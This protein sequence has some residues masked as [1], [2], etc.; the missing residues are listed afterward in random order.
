MDPLLLSENEQ[1]YVFYHSARETTTS[2]TNFV[3]YQQPTTTTT[4][5]TTTA[6]SGVFH[7]QIQ[8][9]RPSAGAGNT[10]HPL[11][12]LS[13]G[14]IASV[15]SCMS[16]YPFDTIKVLLQLDRSNAPA[17][18]SA[19]GVIRHI[20]GSERPVRNLYRGLTPSLMAIIPSQAIQFT[21][22]EK[23]KSFYANQFNCN[24][25][26]PKALIAASAT[27]YLTTCLVTNPLWLVKIRLQ[28]QTYGSALR[29][30]NAFHAFRVIRQEEG[31]LAFYKGI[32]TTVLGVAG[33]CITFPILEYMKRMFAK[34]QNVPVEKLDASYIALSA[35][36][37]SLVSAVTLFP[38]DVVRAR[39][40]TQR[41]FVPPPPA[42]AATTGPA[43]GAAA[44]TTGSHP[45]YHQQHYYTGCID[46]IRK[47]I[48]YEGFS[49]LY[50]GLLPHLMR[51]V[52]ASALTWTMYEVS[53][54]FLAKCVYGSSTEATFTP[55]TTTTSK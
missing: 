20:I 22:Y 1:Y 52:P 15:T 29:Y 31:L 35:M 40:Q 37:A 13:S 18:R 24:T 33:P 39:I 42:P 55:T 28:A 23:L 4:T 51:A 5:S 38:L 10:M 49:S 11:L 17:R 26:D 32:S 3:N 12:L 45:H 16:T 44:A 46:G 34:Q 19:F 14:S 21:A 43:N 53:K 47:I 30:N 25:Y 48:R 7:H 9:E 27:S 8:H 2:A 6:L 54:R 50:R 36:T 41:N